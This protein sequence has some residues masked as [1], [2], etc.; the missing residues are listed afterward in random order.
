MG[1]TMTTMTTPRFWKVMNKAEENEPAEMFLYGEITHEKWFDDDV[2]A[3][4][5]AEDLAA[6]NGCDLKLRIN[7]P[8]GDVFAAQAIYNQLKDYKGRVTA[9]V[10]GLAASAATIITCAGDTVIMPEN[11]LFMIHNPLTWAVGN[12]DEM[13]KT[14][15]NLD[16]VRDTIISVYLSRTQGKVTENEL[17]DMMDAETWLTADEAV[18]YGFADSVT[19]EHVENRINGN[20][21]IMNSIACDLSKFKHGE[22]ARAIFESFQKPKKEE[23]NTMENKETLGLIQKIADKLGIGEKIEPEQDNTAIENAVKAE[24]ERIINLEAMLTGDSVT[25]AI[26]NVAKDT[27]QAADD[28]KGYVDAVKKARENEAVND[29]AVQAMS[30]IIQDNMESGAAG[31][32]ASVPTA[33][34]KQAAIDEIVNIANGE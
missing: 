31:V 30:N 2:T 6:L 27:G 28:I 11:A 17:K 16:I 23:K 25:D 18:R 8:G 21:L 12:A 10:D 4:A 32:T 22:K 15:D 14:A 33:D 7:S 19:N 13:R 34:E 29:A 24:R 3:K 9:Q 5:F 1:K 20:M 26:I